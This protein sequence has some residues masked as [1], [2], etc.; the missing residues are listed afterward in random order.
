[1]LEI[2][3]LQDRAVHQTEIAVHDPRTDEVRRL[4][5]RHLQFANTH[6]PP[7]DVHALDVIALLDPAVTLYG[8][9]VDGA[10]AAVGALKQLDPIHGELKSMHT[11]VE[12]RGRGHGRTLLDHLVEE[13]RGRAWVRLSLETGSMDAFVPARAM[14]A[15][16]G[17]EPCAPFGD[18]RPSRSSVF[19]TL[20]PLERVAARR[21]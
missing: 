19:M 9:R 16:A 17:F 5:E 7:E 2:S 4:L 20:T 10:L 15:A 12:L 8:L 1:M 14:Y 21:G 6:S 11:A 13:A 18:Y 3:T